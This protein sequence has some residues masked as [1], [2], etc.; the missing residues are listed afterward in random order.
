LKKAPFFGLGQKR[1]IQSA[2]F[3]LVAKKAFG[4][5]LF[6]L[7]QKAWGK[8]EKKKNSKKTTNPFFYVAIPVFGF[9]DIFK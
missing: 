9:P 7:R 4:N 8:N 2:S 5:S 1:T 3:E 6:G